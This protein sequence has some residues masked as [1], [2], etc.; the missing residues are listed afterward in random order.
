MNSANIARDFFVGDVICPNCKVLV[1][2]TIPTG[3]RMQSSN[4]DYLEV[5]DFI[6]I[7]SMDEMESAGYKKLSQGEKHGLNLLEIWDCVSC[8]TVFHWAIVRIMK[9]YLRSIKAIQ[10]DQDYLDECHFISEQ[11]IMV[12][13]SICGLPYL[14]FIDKDWITIIRQHL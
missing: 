2:V 11:A 14:D 4:L 6:H 3:I 9:G 5:G 12:A 8:N 13:M 7:P 1:Q 10:L